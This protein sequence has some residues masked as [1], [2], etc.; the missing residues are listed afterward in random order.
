MVEHRELLERIR[1]RLDDSFVGIGEM[2]A[3]LPPA[4]V[5]DLV[6]QLTRQEAAS[7]MSMLSVPRAIEVFDQPTLHR[8]SAILE[9]MERCSP[10]PPWAGSKRR[11]PG[12]WSWRCSSR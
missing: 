6:N 12:P 1:L 4:D 3:E 10:P 8:R 2:V 7:V 11:S 5:A 9:Q